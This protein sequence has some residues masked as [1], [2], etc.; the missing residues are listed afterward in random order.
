MAKYTLEDTEEFL[1]LPDDAVVQVVVSEIEEREV[2]GRDGKDGWS[3]LNFKFKIL[4]LPSDLEAE[5]APLLGQLIFGSVSARLTMHPDN[6]LRQWSEALLGFSLDEP[7][8]ELDT[9][10]LIG[11][12][13][14][15]IITTY[16]KRDSVQKNHKIAALLPLAVA[17][18]GNAP[19]NSSFFGDEPPF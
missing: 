4:E 16:T 11:R 15:G 14:R 8:F 3:K 2:P 1:T 18:V 10:M 9:D 13:A 17:S 6:K 5:F 12:K 7:G 19:A